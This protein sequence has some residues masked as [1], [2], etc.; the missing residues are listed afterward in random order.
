MNWL[1]HHT[2]S[3]DYVAQA[4]EGVRENDTVRATERYLLA[5][6]TEV[7]A[8][9][10][11]EPS[12]QRTLGITAVS[13]ASLYYKAQDFIQAK[14]VAYKWLVTELLP[15]FSVAALEDMLQTILRD[16]THAESSV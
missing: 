15:P 2:L 6:E 5:A 8:L 4:E 13:A 12:K 3:E 11:L 16:K 9:E 14:K 10:S 1:T 7:K